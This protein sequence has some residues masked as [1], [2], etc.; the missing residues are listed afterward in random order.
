[1]QCCE[2]RFKNI[3]M[4]T[5]RLNPFPLRRLLRLA[6]VMHIIEGGGG[7][8]GGG[9]ERVSSSAEAL[10]QHLT[11]SYSHIVTENQY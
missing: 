3:V 1:M 11:V 10:K 7:G 4:A 5:S 6:A 9:T 2:F 8:G